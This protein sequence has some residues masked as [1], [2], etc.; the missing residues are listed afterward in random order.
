MMKKVKKAGNDGKVGKFPRI[1]FQYSLNSVIADT[2]EP[3]QPYQPY[4]TQ[5]KYKNLTE[6]KNIKRTYWH[7]VHL[8]RKNERKKLRKKERVKSGLGSFNFMRLQKV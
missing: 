3:Y 4:Q 8:Y 7:K 5:E 1:Y 2:C 6:K